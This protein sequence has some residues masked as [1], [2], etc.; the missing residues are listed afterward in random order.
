LFC[1][2]SKSNPFFDQQ[3]LSAEQSSMNSLNLKCFSR[4]ELQ[5][6]KTLNKKQEKNINEEFKNVSSSFTN[7]TLF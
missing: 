4:S 6:G 1:F 7:E 5:Y 2:S 3:K